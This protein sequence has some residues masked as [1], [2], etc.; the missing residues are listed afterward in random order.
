MV[1]VAM[2]IGLGGVALGANFSLFKTLRHKL[3]D[4]SIEL[5]SAARVM[6][7]G[8]C[9][10]S[11]CAGIFAIV[12]FFRRRTNALAAGLLICELP[13]VLI[14][15]YAL[16]NWMTTDIW[17]GTSPVCREV[18]K[19]ARD[20]GA[21]IMVIN[22]RSGAAARFYLLQAGQ[23]IAPK[24]AAERLA[25]PHGPMYVV[26]M[27]PYIEVVKGTHEKQRNAGGLESAGL[28]GMKPIKIEGVP[29]VGDTAPISGTRWLAAV[30][31]E[32]RQ[33]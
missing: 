15:Q 9:V 26:G 2:G 32:E 12:A 28:A 33:A 8:A 25:K 17:R 14:Y 19:R 5:L 16:G 3:P 4:V 11:V 22:G 7:V 27:Q 18:R 13:L 20:E 10:V 1:F 23:E 31:D 6:V 29:I 24:E 21:K 30:R